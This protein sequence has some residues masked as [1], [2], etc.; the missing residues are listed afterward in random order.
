VSTIDLSHSAKEA[1]SRQNVRGHRVS[2]SVNS[3]TTNAAPVPVDDTN[4]TRARTQLPWAPVLL[5]LQRLA[6][7]AIGAV[8]HGA[9]YTSQLASIVT[10]GSPIGPKTG[11]RRF[12]APGFVA[13]I[14]S[15]VLEVRGRQHSTCPLQ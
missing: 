11:D 8:R 4:T 1:R 14:K 15:W 9:N 13:E 5:N 10:G 2:A 3:G 7:A 12:A 6:F